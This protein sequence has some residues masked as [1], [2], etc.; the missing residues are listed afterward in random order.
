MPGAAETFGIVLPNV[1]SNKNRGSLRHDT[2]NLYFEVTILHCDFVF[3]ICQLTNRIFD[4]RNNDCD[5]TNSGKLLIDCKSIAMFIIHNMNAEN[6]NKFGEFLMNR[7]A[8]GR[9]G[10][11]MFLK[12][13][14]C[15]WDPLFATGEWLWH[16]AK[17]CDSHP[18]LI[19]PDKTLPCLDPYMALGWMSLYGGL[20]R[21]GMPEYKRDFVW[22]NL[23]DSKAKNAATR[24]TTT[25]RQNMETS[26]LTSE[27]AQERKNEFTSRSM[28][29]GTMTE[30]RVHPDL[31]MAEEYARSGHTPRTNTV[32][33]DAEGYIEQI[34][35][36][37]AP[38]GLAVAGHSLCHFV[39]PTFNFNSVSH[40][41][42]EVERLLEEFV[43]NDIPELQKNGRLRPLFR[44][45]IA[46]VISTFNWLVATFSMDHPMVQLILERFKKVNIRDERVPRVGE[47]ER[48]H[49]IL[50]SWSKSIQ[51]DFD[52]E[53][54]RRLLSRSNKPN[55]IM[56]VLCSEVRKLVEEN[57]Q[58]KQGMAELATAVNNVNNSA[59]LM[60]ENTFLKQQLSLLQAKK[61]EYRAHL[62]TVL[63][64]I[65]PSPTSETVKI[66]DSVKESVRGQLNKRFDVQ[67]EDDVQGERRILQG[68]KN[69]SR[70]VSILFC[71]FQIVD[72]DFIVFFFF[73]HE[74][75][76]FVDILFLPLRP[77]R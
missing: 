38:G 5:V 65:S 18:M 60:E 56:D 68:L 10:E 21:A 73:L 37:T 27:Q 39:P 51:D 49:K 32:N 8:C 64:Q 50:Q 29:K 25:I 31:N 3:R 13:S 2:P 30:N 28:R 69:F 4:S 61:N 74:M 62:T 43:V 35:A 9:G 46:R 77:F 16:A 12:W 15:T 53:M 33:I 70:E 7:S 75:F 40:A 26:T 24:L 54:S 20:E 48:H 66:D 71:D 22:P 6:S 47:L 34:P 19:F 14:E 41:Q 57:S 23:H 72:F 11:Q 17:Q 1:V 76:L 67:G 58:I 36:L 52:N 59:K 44:L 63:D 45:I 42:G 55:E